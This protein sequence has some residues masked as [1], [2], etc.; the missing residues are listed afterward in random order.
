MLHNTVGTIMWRR[1]TVHR[2]FSLGS[3]SKRESGHVTKDKGKLYLLDL[4]TS[5]S[6]KNFPLGVAMRLKIK[7]NCTEVTV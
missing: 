3:V 6:D 1:V 2:L 7:A 4:P 5:A